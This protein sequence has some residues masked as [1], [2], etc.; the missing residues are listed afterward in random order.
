MPYRLHGLAR[1]VG[2][3]LDELGYH[4][5]DVLGISWGGGLAQQFALQNPRRCRRLVLVAT[6]TGSMMVPA[7]PGVLL[8][9]VTPRRYR[10][11]E[12]LL[13]IAGEIYGGRLRTRPDLAEPLIAAH[14]RTSGRG[15]LLQLAGQRGLDQP[16][17]AAAGPAAHPGAGR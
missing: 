17:L 8:R 16:A 10:D 9:M 4:R 12:Y 15:Y 2:G 7:R 11:P 1:L 14:G 6:G 5:F 3:L 13:E